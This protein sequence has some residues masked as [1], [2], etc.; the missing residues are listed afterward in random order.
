MGA[1]HVFGPKKTSRASPDG[2]S[3][4]FLNRIAH[5]FLQAFLRLPVKNGQRLR[6]IDQA[7]FR[8]PQSTGYHI[9][10]LHLVADLHQDLARCLQSSRSLDRGVFAYRRSC[11]T[12]HFINP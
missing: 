1:R 10:W 6:D 4:T 9:V 8:L 2:Q 5:S 3:L 12:I 11:W 7:S